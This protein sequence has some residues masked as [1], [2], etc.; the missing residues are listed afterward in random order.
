[1]RIKGILTTIYVFIELIFKSLRTLKRGWKKPK[2]ELQKDKKIFIMGNG[3]S[4]NEV[5]LKKVLEM[6]MD[7]VCVNFFPSKE[8][9]KF[10]TL[11]PK[12]L[13]LIDGEFFNENGHRK[14][15]VTTVYEILSKINWELTIV[16]PVDNNKK[17]DNSF[18][19]YDKVYGDTVYTK[20]MKTLR[21]FL[22]RNNFLCCG[23]Q[24]VVIAATNYFVNRKVNKIYLAGVDMSEFKMLFVNKEN[25]VVIKTV[26]SYGED[27][28]VISPYQI[29]G[30]IEKG[31][32]YQYLEMYRNMFAQFHCLAEYAKS[33][34]VKI[35][36]LSLESY[37]DVFEKEDSF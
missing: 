14:Q 17:I 16:T 3:P 36:N 2:L 10:M 1:M 13:F 22:Y 8:Y 27:K 37:I 18:I 4:L 23:R 30:I 28:P 19:K 34:N 21:H 6:E 12:Y 11:K 31:G 35:V 26:H 33:Q 5:N 24:N 32:F 29:Y 9:D 20:Q 7:I 15:E 25:D